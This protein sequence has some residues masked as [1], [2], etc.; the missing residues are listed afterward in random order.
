ML[1]ACGVL[2]SWLPRGADCTCADNVYEVMMLIK[3]EEGV[4][5]LWCSGMLKLFAFSVLNRNLGVSVENISSKK[6]YTISLYNLDVFYSR[7][8]TL[9]SI[10]CTQEGIQG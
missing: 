1:V 7:E 9:E 10:P 2:S 3:W 8:S 4:N 5:N 6:F